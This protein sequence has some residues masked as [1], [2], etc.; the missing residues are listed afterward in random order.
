M[1]LICIG[2][3][4]EQLPF[5]EHAISEGHLVYSFD[6]NPNAIGLLHSTQ[7]YD[8]P[9]DFD[10]LCKIIDCI[11]PDGILPVPLGKILVLSGRLNDKYNWNGITEQAARICTDKELF[12]STVKNTIITPQAISRK[13][14]DL[15]FEY[16]VGL[17]LPIIIKPKHG[18][19]SRGVIVIESPS[20]I[21]D[22]ILFCNEQS[23]DE[24]E[25]F[26]IQPFIPGDE[27]GIDGY[28]QNNNTS[29]TCIR[30]K[31]I[32]NLPWR[33]EVG[34]I[35]PSGL[36]ESIKDKV[37]KTINNAIMKIGLNSC[38][39]HADILVNNNS[40][41]VIE[42]SGRPSGLSIQSTILKEV[43]QQNPINL[44]LDI[45]QNHE[46]RSRF[47]SKEKTHLYLGFFDGAGNTNLINPQKYNNLIEYN[48]KFITGEKLSKIKT[49]ADIKNR[50]FFFIKDE[51]IENCIRTKD[52][53]TE[54]TF[55]VNP[56]S[57]YL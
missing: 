12:Y 54:E 49:G 53:I 2:A 24:S 30:K 3:G 57:Y 8:L 17:S 10:E 45:L 55:N 52:L 19:G 38:P 31:E 39:F 50:G 13:R 9:D 43:I 37:F 16:L 15:S 21:N 26:L 14:I 42:I 5:I 11:K 4:E 7:G 44:Y 36:S 27:Y 20:E 51:T 35:Y 23:I 34:Y 46:I 28:V 32:S 25:Q 6:K 1:K 56:R 41:V 40:I 29:I 48:P 18:S 33:Q 22:A 47:I